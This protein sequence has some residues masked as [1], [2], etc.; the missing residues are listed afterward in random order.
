MGSYIDI[1]SHILPQ[2]DDGAK[3]IDISKKMLCIAQQNGIRSMILTPHH[4]PMH[5]SAG[6]R[7]IK[8][9]TGELQNMA[10]REGIE[11]RL[12]TGNEIYYRSDILEILKERKALTLADSMYVLIEFSPMDGFDYIRNGIYQVLSGGYRPILAHVERYGSIAASM[13]RVREIVNMGCY[14]QINAGSIMG[15]YGFGTKK[16][17]RQILKQGLVHFIATDA[18][19][20][21]KRKPCLSDCVKYISKK[22]GKECAGRIFNENPQK[23]INDK[24]L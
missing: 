12:Y 6:P 11:I 5:Y 19:D 13:E 24:Y 21:V 9:L 2:I 15:Q 7:T 22:F 18:H 14:I 1:H 10:D 3:N 16:F 8:S 17:T 4:K 23:I 20:D